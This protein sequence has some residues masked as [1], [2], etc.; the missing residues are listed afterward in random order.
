MDAGLKAPEAVS[1]KRSLQRRKVAVAIAAIIFFVGAIASFR[2]G[3][4]SQK[5][6]VVQNSDSGELVAYTDNC[7]V[8]ATTLEIPRMAHETDERF[9]ACLDAAANGCQV[10]KGVLKNQITQGD[11]VFTT[12]TEYD[13]SNKNNLCLL[14][15]KQV[16]S[17]ATQ[18][19]TPADVSAHDGKT[20][21]C[22]FEKSADL[23][24]VVQLWEDGGL[25]E[26]GTRLHTGSGNCVG[27]YFGQQ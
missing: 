1:P 16:S 15:V 25:L 9:F 5:A 12:S 4:S 23:V 19:T 7:G 22:T 27:S 6:L 13:I 24:E 3:P 17:E 8:G 2:T 18:G 14:K 10:T 20:G 26:A 11:S 21:S